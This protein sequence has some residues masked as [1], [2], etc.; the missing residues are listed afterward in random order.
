[1]KATTVDPS[2]QER[3]EAFGVTMPK[4]PGLVAALR[5]TASAI[6]HHAGLS[7]DAIDDLKIMVAEA[8]SYCIQHGGSGRLKIS[9]DQ[10]DG[11]LTVSVE[12]A[13][14]TQDLGTD[15]TADFFETDEGLFIIKSLAHS[16][17]YRID[18]HRGLRLTFRASIG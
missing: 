14:H 18:P 2:A 5:L 12:D 10:A 8:C 13:E 1:V 4:D 17:E 3:S 7:I 11:F 6:G 15:Q 9:F 16:V